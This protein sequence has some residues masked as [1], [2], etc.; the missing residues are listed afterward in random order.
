MVLFAGTLETCEGPI[1][2][3]GTYCADTGDGVILCGRFRMEGFLT[4]TLRA[5]PIG[6]PSCHLEVRV[7]RIDTTARGRGFLMQYIVIGGPA[8]A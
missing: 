8:D 3:L 7:H 2:C 1:P 5:E 6:V 4:F